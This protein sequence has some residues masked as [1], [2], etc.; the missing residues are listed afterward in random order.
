[1]KGMLWTTGTRDKTRKLVTQE[2]TVLTH[3][4]TREW[5]EPEWLEPFWLPYLFHSGCTVLP[6]TVALPSIPAVLFVPPPA[7]L[8]RVAPFLLLLP[9]SGVFLSSL[10]VFRV[11]LLLVT[12]LT[13]CCSSSSHPLPSPTRPGCVS[14]QP[15]R[16]APAGPTHVLDVSSNSQFSLLWRRPLPLSM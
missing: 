6:R 2:L 13:L 7:A 16:L 8:P 5:L 1:M 10:S 3:G 11:L 4:R 9:R 12:L 15:P 14:Q